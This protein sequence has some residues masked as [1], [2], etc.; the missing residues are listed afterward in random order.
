MVASAVESGSTRKLRAWSWFSTINGF[1]AALGCASCCESFSGFVLSGVI[2]EQDA[3]SVIDKI[4]IN[5]G[6][7]WIRLQTIISYYS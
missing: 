3:S 6:Y 4:P 1:D 5:N 7:F 2:V